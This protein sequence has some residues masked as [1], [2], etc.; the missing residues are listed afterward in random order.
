MARGEH[1]FINCNTNGIPFQHHGIDMGD[2]TVIHLAP[3]SGARIA[4]RDPSAE[5]AV[6]RV[7]MDDFC[8]GAQLEKVMHKNARPAHEI[9]ATAESMLGNTGYSLLEGNCEHF[10]T[11]CAIG[12]GKSQQIELGEATVSAFASMAAKALGTVS[13]RV[14]GKLALKSAT[15]VHPATLLADGI[16]IAAL[17]ISCKQGLEAEKAKRI[18]KVSGTVAAAGIGGI[19][20]GPV[21]AA[22]CLAIHSTTGTIADRLC[23]GVRKILA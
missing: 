15:R 6:R 12:V 13:T 23:Q 18:A 14:G 11:L 10:A 21:G 8:R 19:V 20:G 17:A 1:I 16:E 4:L 9:A 3:Q 7:S 2:G 22:T 5:F